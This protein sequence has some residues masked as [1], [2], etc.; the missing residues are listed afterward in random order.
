[1]NISSFVV[2]AIALILVVVFAFA[3]AFAVM[4]LWNWLMPIIFSLPTITYW[5]AYGLII[6]ANLIFPRSSSSSSK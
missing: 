1:M 5:Q 2:L 3:G 6:L 4:L